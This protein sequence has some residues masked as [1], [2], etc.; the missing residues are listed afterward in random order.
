M[1]SVKDSMTSKDNKDVAAMLS[2]LS[3]GIHAL[4]LESAEI[5]QEVALINSN[6]KAMAAASTEARIADLQKAMTSMQV[7]LDALNA[8]DIT[9]SVVVMPTQ[10]SVV[11]G[12]AKNEKQGAAVA[13]PRLRAVTDYWKK[14]WQEDDGFIKLQ[15]RKLVSDADAKA[16]KELLDVK[17]TARNQLVA[18]K[19]QA[20]TAW[21]ALTDASQSE[22]RAM[23]MNYNNQRGKDAAKDIVDD[24]EVADDKAPTDD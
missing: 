14:M 5:R 2:K 1:K 16:R 24:P 19:K 18:L 17:Q 7:K 4:R 20:T 9:P 12:D 3:D 11:V 21:K 13:A 6:V 8:V 10:P 23:H 15:E 22:V